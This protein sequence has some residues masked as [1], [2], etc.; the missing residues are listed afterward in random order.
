MRQLDLSS[1]VLEVVQ[2]TYVTGLVLQGYGEKYEWD[3]PKTDKVQVGDDVFFKFPCAVSNYQTAIGCHAYDTATIKRKNK[4]ILS[5]S[6]EKAKD[7]ERR[8]ETQH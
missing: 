1:S 4:T 6:G 8:L 5:I 3:I 2:G 7:L